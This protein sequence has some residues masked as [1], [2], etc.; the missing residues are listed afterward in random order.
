MPL[1]LEEAD[2]ASCLPALYKECTW[3]DCFGEVDDAECPA[4]Y[5]TGLVCGTCGAP[6]EVEDYETRT[7]RG[8]CYCHY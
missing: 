8:G 7:S 1:A 2:G 4:C 6:Q 5:G 3:C